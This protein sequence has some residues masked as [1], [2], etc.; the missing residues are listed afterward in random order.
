MVSTGNVRGALKPSYELSRHVKIALTA[1]IT[2][3]FWL[4]ACRASRMCSRVC[5]MGPSVA[6]TTS[7]AP[8][9]CHQRRA[10]T[11]VPSAHQLV[12]A[13]SIPRELAEA[14]SLPA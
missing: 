11:V 7:I 5:G 2:K 12:N 10:Q 6:E 13:A 14:A 4:R 1:Y 9:I 8:S 3:H